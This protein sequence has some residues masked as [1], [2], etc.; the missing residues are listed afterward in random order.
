MKNTLENFLI[1][2]GIYHIVSYFPLALNEYLSNLLSWLLLGLFF[3]F[4]LLLLTSRGQKLFSIFHNR[5][6]RL[7][8]YLSA[9]GVVEY[10]CLIL[11]FIPGIIYGYLSAQA[12]Y[13]GTEPPILPDFYLYFVQYGYFVMLGL[14]LIIATYLSFIK[15]SK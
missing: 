14:A 13:N 12:Q 5:Y 15:K 10:M 7:K 3:V 9:F 11:I 1:L 4:C 6:I 8:N 2:G